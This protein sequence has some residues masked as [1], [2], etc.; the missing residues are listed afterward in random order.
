MTEVKTQPTVKGS[1]QLE[2]LCTTQ[3]ED[4]IERKRRATAKLPT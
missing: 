1:Y 2:Y 4:V 3:F